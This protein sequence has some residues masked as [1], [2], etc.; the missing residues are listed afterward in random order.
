MNERQIAILEQ[1][2]KANR[3]DPFAVD[4]ARLMM[5][6]SQVSTADFDFIELATTY[7]TL[8]GEEYVVRSL[9]QNVTPW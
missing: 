4:R 7:T 6:N 9:R 8:K 3:S 1:V 5:R 2:L